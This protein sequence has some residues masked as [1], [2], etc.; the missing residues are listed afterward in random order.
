MQRFILLRGH[1][2]S[3]KSTFAD[4]L[5]A[6]FAKDY[7][8]ALI[9]RIENDLLLTDDEGNYN[10]SPERLDKAQSQGLAMMKQAL[11][12]GQA[13]PNQDILI[14]NSNTNQKSSACVHLLQMARKHGFDTQV[15]R[16][17][18]FF[19]NTHNV[20][21]R[22]VLSAYVKLN[23]NRLRDEIHVAAIQPMND[24]IK[25]TRLLTWVK[26]NRQF[27]TCT[28]DHYLAR[29]CC[30]PVRNALRHTAY[31]NLKLA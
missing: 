11:K 19:D 17:H 21:E 13:N 8:N 6:Q 9:V 2:G 1:Q 15:Y 16:L 23:Q 27:R 26:R 12:T 29:S 7:P 14:I 25:A 30:I 31:R 20:K 4:E 18:N 24:D 10:W 5:M 28:I 22:D 3:G